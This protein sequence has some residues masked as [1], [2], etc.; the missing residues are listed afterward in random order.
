MG[1]VGENFFD[2][3]Y[4]SEPEINGQKEIT[5]S[6]LF[7]NENLDVL[8]SKLARGSKWAKKK[9]IT[10]RYSLKAKTES[11]LLTIGRRQS[12]TQ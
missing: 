12:I 2:D 5:A 10:F 7:K 6:Y 4:D 11:F 9:S 8:R 1:D 3:L